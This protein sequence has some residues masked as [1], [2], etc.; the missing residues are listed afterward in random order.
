MTEVTQEKVNMERSTIKISQSFTIYCKP[1]IKNISISHKILVAAW[2]LMKHLGVNDLR[3]RMYPQLIEFIANYSSNSW[4]SMKIFNWPTTRLEGDYC[5]NTNGY[6][7]QRPATSG[8]M[9]ESG[10]IGIL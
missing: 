4:K 2:S 9:S 7:C 6:V 10:S 5:E 1:S 8:A 3:A